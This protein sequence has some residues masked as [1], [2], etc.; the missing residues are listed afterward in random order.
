M[1]RKILF[2]ILLSNFSFSCLFAS[3]NTSSRNFEISKSLDIFNSMFRELD[4]FYVDS[5]KVDS[6]VRQTMDQMLVNLDPYTTYIPKSDEDELK[7]MTTGEYG[8]VGALITQRKEQVIISEVYENMPAQK[9]GL[10]AG[11]VL[12][13]IDGE[14]VKGKTISQVSDLLRGE[15][16]TEVSVVYLRNDKTHKKKFQREKIQLNPVDYFDVY[17]EI[18]YIHLSS[19]T[20]KSSE[21][22]K[23]IFL[24]LKTN[25]KIEGLVLDLRGNPGGIVDEAIKICNFFLPKGQVVVE[26]KGKNKQW[27]KVYKTQKEPLDVEIPIAILVN[28]ASASASEIVAGALQDLDRAVVIGSRTYGKGLVQTTRPLSY[29]GYLKV[30]TAKY[31]TPSGRCIQAIDY[32]HKNKDGRAERIPDS[33]TSVFKTTKG[34]V[35]RDGGGVSPD[36]II[37][38][39]EVLD[40]SYRL[41]SD[42]F[43][44]DFVT[45]YC[46]KH[47]QL[48]PVA[49][50]VF[51]DQDYLDF[52]NFLKGKDF[53]YQL[54]SS[55]VLK[56]LK[57]IAKLEGYLD[58]SEKEF[59]ALE[60]KLT[61]DTDKDL[62]LF[63]KEIREL[64]SVEIVK[65]YYFQKG[66]MQESLKQDEGL[67]NA[68]DILKDKK[69]YK[70]YLSVTKK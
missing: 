18:A 47:A 37:K 26:T 59:E 38:E 55:A 40:I 46:K 70:S 25:K 52:K 5:I 8:G 7:Y 44:F 1:N 34:R 49:D 56:N 2:F 9:N 42:F 12:L 23:K 35:V 61:P 6:F 51:S 66:A 24:D 54:R 60:Q 43:I 16:S 30:T 22:I 15:P 17:D 64:L 50:F 48:P 41:A 68:L 13:E 29:G 11:D 53:S 14:K 31:Y 45:E 69:T 36:F 27:D 62:D 67:K 19:F 63:E 4:L 20:D 58:V 57:E 3:S 33:L 39:P 21:E 65:R 32:E 28:G 10:V